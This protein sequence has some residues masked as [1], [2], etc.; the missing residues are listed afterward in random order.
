MELELVK[1]LNDGIIAAHFEGI[2]VFIAAYGI[3]LLVTAAA[4]GI[5]L[6]NVPKFRS[7]LI[8]AL[9][10][11]TSKGIGWVSYRP[12]PFIAGNIPLLV[13]HAADSSFPSDHATLAFAAAA[14]F[15][16]SNRRA[17][18]VFGACALL[19]SFA[20]IVLGLHYP[21]DIIGSMA[22]SL[23]ITALV[24]RL[25]VKNHGKKGKD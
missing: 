19:I 24:E 9:S 23:G 11:L 20:R 6:Y 14:I 16:S 17:S 25:W 15:W 13:Q 7:L 22:V 10:V 4:A 21:T 5:L 8:V 18:V 3:Y 1:A 2:A 12:R